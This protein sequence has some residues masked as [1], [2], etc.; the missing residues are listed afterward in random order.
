MIFG[1]FLED[2]LKFF[3][4]FFLGEG[5]CLS[6]FSRVFLGFFLGFS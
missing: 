6:G 4:C 5:V 3:V 2:F 1:F